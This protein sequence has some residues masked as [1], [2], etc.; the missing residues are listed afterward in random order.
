MPQFA[1][2]RNMNTE[3][4]GRFPFLVDVQADL[5]E[6]IHTRVVIPLASAPELT[7]FPL[8]YL[9]PMVTFNEACYLL[10]TP[11]M[12][13]ISRSELGPEVGTVAD[14]EEAVGTAIE[15]LMRGF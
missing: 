15:F 2:Y 13:G 3:T 4:S 1:V 11:Q 7:R 9:T 5:F 14:Q 8:A 12:A 6:D 10:M